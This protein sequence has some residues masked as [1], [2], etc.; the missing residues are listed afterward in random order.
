MPSLHLFY[1]IDVC[2][3]TDDNEDFTVF[4]NKI[5]LRHHVHTLRK[6]ITHSN[7]FNAVLGTQ[8]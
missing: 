6:N 5:C 4:N 1:L 2:F 8:P 3:F 7:N